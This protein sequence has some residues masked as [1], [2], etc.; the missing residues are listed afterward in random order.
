VIRVSRAARAQVASLAKWYADR[1]RP[2]A[3]RNLRSAIVAA[4]D[5]IVA[6]RGTFFWAPRPYPDLARP[7]WR[8]LKEGPYWIAYAPDRSGP[9]IRA[10]FYAAADIPNRLQDGGL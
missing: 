7:G 3:V 9:V 6:Q 2:E 1:N 5:R 10:V 8:W 4:A